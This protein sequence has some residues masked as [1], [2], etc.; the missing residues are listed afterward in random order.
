MLAPTMAVV[1]PAGPSGQLHRLPTLG[2]LLATAEGRMRQHC[3]FSNG[4]LAE[5]RES[6]DLC[7]ARKGLFGLPIFSLGS[8][9]GS[10]HLF[11]LSYRLE[12]LC[13]VDELS[14]RL[15]PNNWNCSS[16]SDP[17]N[18]LKPYPNL[19]MYKQ[20]ISFDK[21]GPFARLFP[22][23][24]SRDFNPFLIAALQH[25]LGDPRHLADSDAGRLE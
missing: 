17:I 9:I 23:C 19:G 20:S 24:V 8:K 25:S 14:P 4:T 18:Q 13:G 22:T 1:T 6:T 10:Y 3:Q 12:R 15:C 11:C 5:V 16:F 2:G 21:C 7:A